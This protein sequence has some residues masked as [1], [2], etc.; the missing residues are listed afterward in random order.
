M[1]GFNVIKTVLIVG[2]GGRVVKLLYR[3]GKNV[4]KIFVRR[5]G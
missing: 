1:V 3:A 5:V 2:Y 4:I